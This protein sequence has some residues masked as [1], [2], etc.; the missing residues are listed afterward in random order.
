MS[1]YVTVLVLENFLKTKQNMLEN[2]QQEQHK[3]IHIDKIVMLQW[4]L[5]AEFVSFFSGHFECDLEDIYRVLPAV[6]GSVGENM[7]ASGNF[8]GQVCKGATNPLGVN[9]THE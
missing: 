2:S 8:E 7:T 4:T 9:P 5:P 6:E 3:K 1:V